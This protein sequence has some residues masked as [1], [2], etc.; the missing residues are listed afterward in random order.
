MNGLRPEELKYLRIKDSAKE[1]EA[2]LS[3]LT[4]EGEMYG[5][6]MQGGRND[7]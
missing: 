3:E 4:S 2:K 5:M 6:S 7:R 1:K